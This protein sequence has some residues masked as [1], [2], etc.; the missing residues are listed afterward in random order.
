MRMTALAVHIVAGGLGIAFGFVA[1]YAAK[2]AKLHRKSGMVFV[3]AMTTMAL[4]G[5]MMA[6]VWSRAPTSNVPVGLLTA[7]LVITA[8]ATVRPASAGSRWL[9]LGLML[10]ALGVGL[11]LFAFGVEA[12]AS[13]K[14]ALNGIPTVPFFI[15]GSIAL[16]ASVGDIRLIRSGG[17]RAIS[18]TPRLT[19]HLWRMCVAL[20]IAAFSFFLGQAEVI[21]KPIRIIP[22]LVIP[23]LAV[24]AALLYWVWRVGIRRTFRGIVGVSAPAVVRPVRSADEPQLSG[25]RAAIPGAVG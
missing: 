25:R 10:V 17:V 21:P 12:L 16:L 24:L 22:L 2:G 14:G 20:L 19:R 4:M 6:A 9:D 11:A 15:F 7:Y 5:A 18:G 13:P 8:L 23:P 3:Y 1:L